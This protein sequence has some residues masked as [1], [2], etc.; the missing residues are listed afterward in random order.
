MFIAD[1]H[2]GK[3]T[4]FRK[5]GIPIPDD[6][7]GTNFVHLQKLVQ[8]FP[9]RRVIFLGD[10]FHSQYNNE[11]DA[12]GA[13]VRS[14]P[15]IQFDLVMGNHDILLE[16]HYHM[17]HLQVHSEELILGPFQLTHEPIE[18]VKEGLYNLCGHIHPAVGLRGGAKQYLKLPC[19]YFGKQQG[20]L[21]AFGEFTGKHKLRPNKSTQVYV[22]AENEV[23]AAHV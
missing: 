22:I 20:I 23:I 5:S 16:K 8:A 3:V 10:L 12:F 2:L 6:A 14:F 18:E 7:K 21:P 11:W 19:F 13:W 9:V 4:H 15:S 17:M 1:V